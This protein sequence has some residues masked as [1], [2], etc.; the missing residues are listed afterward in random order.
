MD[1]SES[2]IKIWELNSPIPVRGQKSYV[3]YCRVGCVG[4]T[5]RF[6]TALRLQMSC[7]SGSNH[8]PWTECWFAEESEL[9][10]EGS[11]FNARY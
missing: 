2:V 3:I 7:L 10:T 11:E 1:C 6:E 9:I 4:I 5:V 8:L